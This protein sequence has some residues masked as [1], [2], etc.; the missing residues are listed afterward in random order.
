M[1]ED[2]KDKDVMQIKKIS[3]ITSRVGQLEVQS[4]C[5]QKV[6]ESLRQFQDAFSERRTQLLE[7]NAIYRN[8]S[9]L[10]RNRA[11]W[12]TKVFVPLSYDAVERKTSMIHQALWG[13]RIASP[14]TVLGKT[15]EDHKFAQS[16]E[17]Y[18]NNTVDSIGFYPVSEEC[19]RSS[20][21]YGLGVYRYG[22]MKRNEDYLWREVQRD[23]KG[24]VVRVNDKPVYKF[25]KKRVKVSRPFIRSVDI[26]DRFFWDPRA[27]RI[28]KWDCE[29]VGEIVDESYEDIYEK[30]QM[31]IYDAGSCTRLGMRDPHGIEGLGL[32]DKGPQ[33]RA[34]EGLGYLPM[35]STYAVVHWYGWFDID[36]DKR[37]EFVHLVVADNRVIL[38]AEENLLQEY[39]FIDVP[40]SRSLHSMTSWGVV[41]PVVGLQYY[42]NELLN[43][44]GDAVKLKINPQFVIN[45]DKIL[46]DHPYISSPGAMHPFYGGENGDVNKH[47]Q[48]VQFQSLEYVSVNE[49]ERIVNYFGR[50]T[51][52]S[53]MNEALTSSNKDT[54]ATTVVSIL[55]EMQAGGSMIVNGILERHGVLGSRILK[56][57][58]LFGD[59]EFVLRSTGRRGLEFR[60]ESLENILGDFDVKVTTSTFLGNRQIELQQLIQLKPLWSQAPHIDQIELDKAILENILP[61][62]VDKIL[63]V[64][65][66]P[67]TPLQEQLLFIAGQ[68]EAVEISEQEPL[69]DLLEKIKAHQKFSNGTFFRTKVDGETK[70]EFFSYLSKLQH[71]AQE[72]QTQQALLQ[73]QAAKGFGKEA[74]A[75]EMMGDGNM[76]NTGSPMVREMGN[77]GQFPGQ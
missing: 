14:F 31:G 53:D 36:N 10:D 25:V 41:D 73:Q 12:Q 47:M 37:R 9:Y 64:P 65:T 18:V 46:E 20:C 48:P 45:V 32:D 35:K 1:P 6:A 44:R 49:E 77:M 51:G 22:W 71:R 23:E 62:R 63:K 24:K 68:G 17:L 15:G 27:K 56:L 59:E 28:D 21:K 70:E 5:L 4:K 61:K 72:L 43:Q 76:G 34:D 8:K 50:A 74:P 7:I 29:F 30:E 11:P 38:M 75:P 60:S 40:F 39:P 26:V 16:A 67:L 33:I 19:L 66:D 69:R 55:N 52:V 54:P 57:L 3:S 13:N 42:V 58:Q 2:N